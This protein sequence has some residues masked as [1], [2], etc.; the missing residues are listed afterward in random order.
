MILPMLRCLS[1]WLMA[2]FPLMLVAQG[3][4][5]NPVP[6][7]K[8]RI[9]EK[10]SK[11]GTYFVVAPDQS[12]LFFTGDQGGDWDMRRISGW[13]SSSPKQERLVLTGPSREDMENSF[14][15]SNFMLTNDGRFAL[16]RVERDA[17][18]MASS[19][20]RNS[21]AIINVVD[22][23]SFSIVSTLN[24]TD[25]LLAG[26]VWQ[27]FEDHSIL[28]D[29][30]ANEKDARGSTFT[31][32]SIALLEVSTMQPSMEC[33][34]L[35][36]YGELKQDGHGGLSRTTSTSDMSSGCAELMHKT[37]A[38]G[39]DSIMKFRTY[40]RAANELKFQPKE[41]SGSP[42]AWHGCSLVDERASDNLALFNCG[43]GHQ[44]WYDTMKLDSRAFFAV[45]VTTGTAVL[46]MAVN[47]S[48][49]AIGHLTSQKGK[50]WLALLTDNVDLAFYPIR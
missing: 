1:L 8:M 42:A 43:N 6:A 41:F 28:A 32:E 17:P 2:M 39:P 4:S 12:L 37:N 14:G 48:K 3:K 5:T 25:K 30:G 24:T 31:R 26:G 22:L 27:P 29:Y 36:H 40:S 33:N 11:M 18:G 15:H 9:T 16:A 35:L 10:R 49:S 13:D 34:Y 50:S 46:R 7:Y 23:Q 47:P 19:F 21:Q 45:D 20:R 44:T 38:S